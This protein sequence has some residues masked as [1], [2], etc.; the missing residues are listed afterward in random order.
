[1]R[2]THRDSESVATEVKLGV[3]ELEE[4]RVE[5]LGTLE[6]AFDVERLEQLVTK[7]PEA[8][9]DSP[10]MMTFTYCGYSIQVQSNGTI[11]IEN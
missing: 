7:N 8:H 11:R 9:A 2:L 5:D 10:R 4:C 1:M 6:E 3:A